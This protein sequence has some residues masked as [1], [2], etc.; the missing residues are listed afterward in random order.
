MS[1][2][3]SRGEHRGREAGVEGDPLYTA[4]VRNVGGTA[5]AVSM[6]D[7][8]SLPT[9][10]PG[11]PREGY[12]PEQFL[13]M[14]WST[15]LGE[16]LKVVIAARG[17]AHRGRAR[18]EVELRPEPRGGYFFVPTA[19]ISVE[20][21]DAELAGR[22]AEAA[23]A[24]CPVSKLLAGSGRATVRTEPWEAGAEAWGEA[25]TETA[26]ERSPRED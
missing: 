13:A 24:R 25:G 26:G 15:C 12:D 20:G 19:Y 22:L 7:G 10:G 4:S 14:A 8:T 21:A 23:H 5:G 18:V 2:E 9:A 6:E 17:L 3:S 11:E 16:T 1:Q